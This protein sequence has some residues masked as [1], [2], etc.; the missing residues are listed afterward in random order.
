MSIGQIIVLAAVVGAFV[1]FAAVLGWGDYYPAAGAP[2]PRSRPERRG[3]CRFRNGFE[4][5]RRRRSR[6]VKDC[7]GALASADR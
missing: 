3:C 6:R 7:P 5:G 2:H 1:L 4:E